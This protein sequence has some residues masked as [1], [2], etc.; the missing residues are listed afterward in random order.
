MAFINI[1]PMN[2]MCL[3]TQ[4]TQQIFLP[5]DSP[6]TRFCDATARLSCLA[7]LIWAFS[8]SSDPRVL[9][10]MKE[11][12]RRVTTASPGVWVALPWD[13]SSI[14]SDRKAGKFIS[15][16]EP[17]RVETKTTQAWGGGKVTVHQVN[18]PSCVEFSVCYSDPPAWLRFGR[19]YQRS[20]SPLVCLH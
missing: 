4:R 2:F 9:L 1:K 13:A 17:P 18:T 10:R 19:P 6:T 15:N 5:F 14:S 16:Q 20:L 7:A 12:Q 11:M 8:P 3:Y